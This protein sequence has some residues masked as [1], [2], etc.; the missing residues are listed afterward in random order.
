M[1]LVKIFLNSSDC[2]FTQEQFTDGVVVK[3]SISTCILE[4]SLFKSIKASFEHYVN[5]FLHTAQRM[6]GF[7]FT[8]PFSAPFLLSPFPLVNPQD[9]SFLKCSQ[10]YLQNKKNRLHY[11]QKRTL[12]QPV[13]AL[14]LVYICQCY[15]L[16]NK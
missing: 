16:S 4:I 9:G 11:Y 10:T 3:N 14:I 13:L 6:L 15:S 12:F 7:E 2:R 8:L 1:L 5:G